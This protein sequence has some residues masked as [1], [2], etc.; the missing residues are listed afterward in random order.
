MGEA[1]S[2]LAV[3]SN[4]PRLDFALHDDVTESWRCNE[5][6]DWGSRLVTPCK[7]AA[8]CGECVDREPIT[9]DEETSVVPVCCTR[10][11]IDE[12][13]KPHRPCARWRLDAQ[14]H[15]AEAIW[16]A[17]GSCAERSVV[18]QQRPCLREGKD[19]CRLCAAPPGG[20]YAQAAG[21]RGDLT[22]RLCC[23]GG[24]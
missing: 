13:C 18:T 22:A 9:D 21:E 8:A 20:A 4:C 23:G 17:L 5:C 14:L 7:V 6:H 3:R 1:P 19:R 12:R 24:D 10:F 11:V 2:H 15:A 16:V